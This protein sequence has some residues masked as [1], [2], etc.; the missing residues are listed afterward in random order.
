M[1]E[2]RIRDSITVWLARLSGNGNITSGGDDL[3]DDAWW[4]LSKGKEV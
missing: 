2:V 3:R 1:E 4:L